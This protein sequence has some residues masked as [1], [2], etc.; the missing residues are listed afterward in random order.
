[1]YFRTVIR[2]KPDHVDAY[3]N[4]GNALLLEGN[5]EE[6]IIHY[7]IALKIRPEFAPAH[8]NLGSAL[9]VLGKTGEA[10]YHFK[11]AKQ[12]SK[13]DT[14]HKKTNKDRNSIISNQP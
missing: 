11:M 14:N 13:N 9:S 6:A 7:Q 5:I 1:M 2:I 3:I 12:F 10:A 8:N 4:L